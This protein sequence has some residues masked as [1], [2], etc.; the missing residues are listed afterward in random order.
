MNESSLIRLIDTS[1]RKE[2]KR[3]EDLIRESFAHNSTTLSY[4][5]TS[6]YQSML[7][8]PTNSISW[9]IYRRQQLQGVIFCE[10]IAPRLIYIPLLAVQPS[11]FRQGLGYALFNFLLK[12]FPTS[13]FYGE[14]AQRNVAA[15][16]LY[17]QQ[18][19]CQVLATWGNTSSDQMTT[20][21]HPPRVKE[22]SWKTTSTV[23][24]TLAAS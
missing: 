1:R 11:Y 7:A 2:K 14:V 18:F 16:S 3:I 19:N 13:Q 5:S 23:H 21:W 9:G 22:L 15:M 24:Q 6:S 12:R 20:L 8:L 4:Q 17:T 10:Q